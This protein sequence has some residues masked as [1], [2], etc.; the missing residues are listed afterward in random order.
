MRTKHPITIHHRI[1]ETWWGNLQPNNALYLR[2]NV[3]RALHTLFQDDTPIQR[4]RRSLEA[5]KPVLHPDV[6]LEISRVLQRF[7]KIEMNVYDPTCFNSDKFLKKC[8]SN[9]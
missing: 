7:E 6:Y 8:H 4:I 3:H 5:D 1:P 2:E 9:A